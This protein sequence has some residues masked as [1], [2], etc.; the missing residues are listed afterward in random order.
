MRLKPPG[1]LNGFG[2]EGM[3]GRGDSWSSINYYNGNAEKP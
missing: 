2:V 3:K 1:S